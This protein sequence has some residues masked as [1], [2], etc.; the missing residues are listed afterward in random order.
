ML[1]TNFAFVVWEV[2][3][4]V[5]ISNCILYLGVLILTLYNL[6]FWEKKYNCILIIFRWSLESTYTQVEHYFT[7]ISANSNR[8]GIIVVTVPNI[9]NVCSFYS[10]LL[11]I[12][13]MVPN[14]SFSCYGRTYGW[15]FDH[16]S[17]SWPKN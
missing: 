5:N 16:T 10:N 3:T 13:P 11:F 9:S 6:S 15:V 7:K 8:K 17:V 4:C 1:T 14:L 2:T 12:V